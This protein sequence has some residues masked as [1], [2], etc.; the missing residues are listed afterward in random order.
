MDKLDNMTNSLETNPT[1]NSE[2]EGLQISFAD[3]TCYNEDILAI[4]TLIMK[5]TLENGSMR[6]L[7]EEKGKLPEKVFIIDY[8]LDRIFLS[9]DPSATYETIEDFIIRTWDVY[10][11]YD[12]ASRLHVNWTFYIMGIDHATDW[13]S[14][15]DD[16]LLSDNG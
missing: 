3:E 14:G 8:D 15:S 6:S 13:F 16:I 1:L 10:M 11:P 12:S 7:L 4:T 2:R 5:K 9:L